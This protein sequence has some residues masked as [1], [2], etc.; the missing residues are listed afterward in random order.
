M[1][2]PLPEKAVFIGSGNFG[3][4]KEF[5]YSLH[6]DQVKIEKELFIGSY[7]RFT[8]DIEPMEY[9]HFFNLKDW[10][11]NYKLDDGLA[12]T[13]VIHV[14]E[15]DGLEY[16]FSR[17]TRSKI[18]FVKAKEYLFCETMK[19][20]DE[21][22]YVNILTSYDDKHFPI[23]PKKYDRGIVKDGAYIGEKQEDGT[24][25]YYLY[26]LLT[27]PAKMSTKILKP[28]LKRH[29][30]HFYKTFYEIYYDYKK[31]NKDNWEKYIKDSQ[32]RVLPDIY[33]S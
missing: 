29:F 20:M 6:I 16:I 3:F 15:K 27:A 5:E 11:D 4:K 8:S 28:F 23:S 9:F 7:E 1:L 22:K 30:A 13:E 33:I 19:K 24:W 26:T 14:I 10:E 17:Q 31:N 32:D 21:N 18:L 12:S 2:A 25:K